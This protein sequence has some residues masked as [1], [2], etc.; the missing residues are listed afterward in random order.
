MPTFDVG[1][2]EITAFEFGQ[3]YLFKQYFDK[4]DLFQQ[5]QEYY[6]PDKCRFE[7]P[8][9][10]LSEV[11][12]ILDRFFNELRIADEPMD[13]CVVQKKQ[14]DSSEI[15]RNSV[16]NQRRGNY[17]IYLMKNEL[18]VRQAVKKGATRL[19]KTDLRKENLQWKIDGS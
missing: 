7:I 12:Q 4:D 3:T 11:S 13:Y 8:G 6:N 17:E 2:D 16:A 10:E 15:L 19:G 18:S 9:E 1:Q 14:V 5:H